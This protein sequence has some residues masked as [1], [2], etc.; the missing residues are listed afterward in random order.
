M[1]LVA[2]EALEE[3]E[4]NIWRQFGIWGDDPNY[5]NKPAWTPLFEFC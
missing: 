5:D 1:E 3:E 2:E 4:P